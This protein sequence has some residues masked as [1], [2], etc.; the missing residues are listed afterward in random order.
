MD[1]KRELLCKL[2]NCHSDARDFFRALSA[3]GLAIYDT[4]TH[5]AVPRE[6]TEK[7]V[8]AGRD[9]VRHFDPEY[10]RPGDTAWNVYLHMLSAAER[11]DKP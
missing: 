1:E 10:D 5:A 9:D 2:L 8:D 6:P 11:E 4:K 7:M 3:A